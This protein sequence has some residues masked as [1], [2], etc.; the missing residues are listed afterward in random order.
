MNAINPEKL[1]RS[2]WTAVTPR[3][4]EKHFMVTKLVRD[5]QERVEACLL[6]AVLT[7]QVYKFPWQELKDDAEW[8]MGWK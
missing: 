4:K 5:E 7:K 6:E 1:L 2:K 8:H 3:N